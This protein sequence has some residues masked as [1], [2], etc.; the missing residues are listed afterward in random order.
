M[1]AVRSAWWSAN[2]NKFDVAVAATLQQ[3]IMDMPDEK[4]VNLSAVQLKDP[5]MFLI[6]MICVGGL[7]VHQFMLGNTGKGIL[8]LCTF[9]GCGILWWIDLFTITGTVKKANYDA[10]SPYL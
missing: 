9:C 7:G 6:I 2:Q 1:N 10:I 4:F 5:T 3:K 8:E